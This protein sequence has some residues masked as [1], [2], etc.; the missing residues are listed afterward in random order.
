[1]TNISVYLICHLGVPVYVGAS[2]DPKKRFSQHL[3][4]TL[5]GI[6]KR[7]LSVTILEVCNSATIK[8]KECKWIKKYLNDG[9][10][11]KNKKTVGHA[12]NGK[13][14]I[15]ISATIKLSLYLVVAK[16][17]QEANR[18]FSQ[19]VEILLLEAIETRKM[20]LKTTSQLK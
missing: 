1:M 6:P 18:S 8:F 2:H 10:K 9:F 4:T 13:G 3:C 11:L 12:G 14:G 15:Q 17:A 5:K 7:E 19:M 20:S 16:L